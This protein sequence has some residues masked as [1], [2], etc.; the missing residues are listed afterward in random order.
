MNYVSCTQKLLTAYVAEQ[1][2]LWMALAEDSADQDNLT[3]D[4]IDVN[5]N[6]QECRS[7]L[8]DVNYERM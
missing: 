1:A 2:A 3:L 4:L 7:R 8:G 6:I 5:A